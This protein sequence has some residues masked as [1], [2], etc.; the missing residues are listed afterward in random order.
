MLYYK[1]SPNAAGKAHGLS[2]L[3]PNLSDR[4]LA[5]IQRDLQKMSGLKVTGASGLDWQGK[6]QNIPG[7]QIQQQILAVA[8]PESQAE[9][10]LSS[11]FQQ[12]LIEYEQF[13]ET[14]I[15]V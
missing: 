1:T 7:S 12:A 14:E 6:F 10:V 4:L 15:Q 11:T 9:T 5:S 2:S 13:Y 8:V 3:M